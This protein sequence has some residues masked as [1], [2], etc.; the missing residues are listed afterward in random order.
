MNDAAGDVD[1]SWQPDAERR[2]ARMRRFQPHR[3]HHERANEF[4]AA[5][6]VEGINGRAA[7]DDRAVCDDGGF[8]RGAAEINADGGGKFRVQSSRCPVEESAEFMRIQS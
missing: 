6:R 3:L 8:D 1:D 2:D 7:L 5:L 4:L